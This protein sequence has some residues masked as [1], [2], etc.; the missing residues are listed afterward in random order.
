MVDNSQQEFCHEKDTS[1][2]QGVQGVRVKNVGASGY[3]GEGLKSRAT[4]KFPQQLGEQK[5]YNS[6]DSHVVT[7]HTTN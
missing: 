3:L 1:A 7:H 5:T 6:Q 4:R 2:L